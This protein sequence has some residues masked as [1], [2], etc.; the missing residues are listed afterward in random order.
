[1]DHVLDHGDP[2]VGGA[3]AQRPARPGAQAPVAAEA[4]GAA[5]FGPG[6]RD[7][8]LARALAVV[9]LALG[10]ELLGRRAVLRLELAFVAGPRD[11]P[12]F[13]TDAD[14]GQRGDDALGPLRPVARG[15]GVLDAQHELAARLLGQ[16]PVVQRGTRPADV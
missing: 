4:V 12:A 5:P 10:V 7:H 3:E 9:R 8:I 13:G 1:A 16:R 11:H 2:V 15:V 6:A 14:P